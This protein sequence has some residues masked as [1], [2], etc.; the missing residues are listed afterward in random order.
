MGCNAYNHRPGCD[1]GWGGIFYGLGLSTG[2][3]YWGRNES[4]T[5]PNAHCPQC[6]ALVFFYRSPHGGSVYFDDLGPP[7]PKHLC[8]D[9]G[10]RS[11]FAKRAKPV[12]AS[13]SWMAGGWHPLQC[14][15]IEIFKDDTRLMAI[16]VSNG[17]ERKHLYARKLAAVIKPHS[18]MLWKRKD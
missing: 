7:W 17:E 5:N 9:A 16:S 3:S 4:Y 10:E 1:C 6:G 11:L 12:S 15:R 2:V 13:L 8:M 14:D 18:P